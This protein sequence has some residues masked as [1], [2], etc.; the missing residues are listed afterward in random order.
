[1]NITFKEWLLVSDVCLLRELAFSR[2]TAVAPCY[3]QVSVISTFLSP[4]D[5]WRSDPRLVVWE[6]DPFNQITSVLF[7]DTT[8]R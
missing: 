3:R 6:R 4:Q 5:I 8:T 7:P 1:M 2:R